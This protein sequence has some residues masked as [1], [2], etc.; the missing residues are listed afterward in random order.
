MTGVKQDLANLNS[1]YDQLTTERDD[2]QD[3]N[4]DLEARAKDLESQTELAAR[5]SLKKPVPHAPGGEDKPKLS[6]AQVRIDE[7]GYPQLWISLKDN[8]GLDK[9]YYVRSYLDAN[10]EIKEEYYE[11][12]ALG[13]AFEA[14]RY[15]TLKDE[16]SYSIL[17]QNN[18]GKLYRSGVTVLLEDV[19]KNGII[20]HMTDIKGNVTDME[21]E[22]AFAVR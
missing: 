22:G 9:V 12:Y 18:N 10:G 20:D 15:R 3:K 11:L 19:D 4:D 1:D 6:W 16:G 21:I 14:I 13:G 5:T 2:L 7:E 17:I 8:S